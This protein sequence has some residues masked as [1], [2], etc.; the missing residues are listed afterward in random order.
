[1]SKIIE[2]KQNITGLR[3]ADPR[4]SAFFVN[5]NHHGTGKTIGEIDP[6]EEPGEMGYVAWFDI[7]DTVGN[8]LAKVN[9]KHVA[10]II[11]EQP[12]VEEKDVPF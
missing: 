3:P 10:E 1:M 11:Y 4:G 9:S 7:M 5:S 8:L 12:K 6:Y 2:E